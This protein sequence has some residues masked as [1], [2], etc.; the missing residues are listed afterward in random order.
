L[1]PA[2]YIYLTSNGNSTREAGQIQLRRRLRSGFTATAQYTYSKALDDAPLMAGGQ[3]ATLN[4]GG[5]AIAQNWLDLGAERGPSNFD[6]RHQLTIQGQYSTG[7]GV[8]GGALLGGLK[9]AAFKE[10]TITSSLNIG[11]GLPE[12][13]IYFAAVSGTGVTGNLRPDL[14]GASIY[15]AP[16]GLFLNPAAFREPAPGQWGDSGRNSITGPSQFGLNASLGRTFRWGGLSMD[17]RLD[18]T[19]VLNHVTFKSWNTTVNNEQFGLPSGIN[20]MRVVQ[21]TLRF[22]F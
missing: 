10:W 5:T 17:L 4:T 1:N 14:T 19:N 3:V 8:P 21:P 7:V 18:V 12:T 22:R 16:A 9:G 11:S 13:P 15:A 20:A 2:G 6:Q